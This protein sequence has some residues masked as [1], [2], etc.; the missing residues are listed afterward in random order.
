MSEK[1]GQDKGYCEG[2]IAHF[3]PEGVCAS[4]S[5]PRQ[6]V[7]Q[8]V[9]DCVGTVEGQSE[10]EDGVC[11]AGDDAHKVRGPHQA[12]TQAQFH[13]GGIKQQPADGTIVVIGHGGEQAAS[14]HA[15]EGKEMQLGEVDGRWDG[16]QEER[17]PASILGTM[18]VV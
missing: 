6:D 17:R 8:E 1:G 5:Q 12:G 18:V 16:G 14:C 4:Q 7:T 11:G 2:K 10:D 3:T 15:K 13:Q 9:M